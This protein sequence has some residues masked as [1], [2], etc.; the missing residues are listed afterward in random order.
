MKSCNFIKGERQICTGPRGDVWSWVTEKG[1]QNLIGI[2]I[3]SYRALF[4][5]D[6]ESNWLYNGT[7]LSSVSHHWFWFW[8]VWKQSCKVS[9]ATLLLEKIGEVCARC[10]LSSS[11]K[12]LFF[13]YVTNGVGKMILTFKGNFRIWINLDDKQQNCKQSFFADIHLDIRVMWAYFL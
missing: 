11:V 4:V 5:F 12:Y 1:A 13:T 7:L 3:G 10:K 9:M 6:S 2:S 8:F